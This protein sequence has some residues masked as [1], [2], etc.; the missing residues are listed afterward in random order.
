MRRVR[1]RAFK[2]SSPSSLQLPQP[3]RQARDATFE[4]LELADVDDDGL[5]AEVGEELG[6]ARAVGGHE[7]L[8]AA[9]QHDVR[10]RTLPVPA[11]TGE[12]RRVVDQRRVP[13]DRTV[14]QRGDRRLQ[15]QDLRQRDGDDGRAERFED[16]AQL[17]DA[18]A[19]RASAP[20]DVDGVSD[21]EDVAAVEGSRCMDAVDRAP[22]IVDDL[23]DVDDLGL[24]GVGARAG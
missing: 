1:D 11:R 3:D 9:E 15:V 24:A 16:R 5:V 7:Q 20:A 12:E 21:L 22:E 19:V 23:L 10:S 8:G 13:D 17:A 18:L 6:A 4:L 14:G 2:P